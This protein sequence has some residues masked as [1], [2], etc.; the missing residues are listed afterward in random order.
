MKPCTDKKWQKIRSNQPTGHS[1]ENV[2]K[3]IL[4]ANLE[5]GLLPGAYFTYVRM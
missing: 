2:T 5:F 3:S 4:N 1:E